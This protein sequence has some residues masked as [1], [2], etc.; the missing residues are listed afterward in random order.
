MSPKFFGLIACYAACA[1]S[2]PT[3]SNIDK[4]SIAPNTQS[5]TATDHGEDVISYGVHIGIAYNGGSGCNDVYNA[6]ED[7]TH[8]V[9]NWQCVDDG[10]GDTQL[11]FNDYVN[12]QD[13][14]NSA[15]HRMYPTVNSFNC[16][17]Y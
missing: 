11:Y 14:I 12:N 9:S 8:Y 13:G 3:A 5:C 6:L 7:A 16:P 2:L 4:R 17:G 1:L 15:L 10:S